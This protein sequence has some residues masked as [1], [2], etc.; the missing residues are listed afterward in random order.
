M[1][2]VE[3]DYL[4][5][6]WLDVGWYEMAGGDFWSWLCDLMPKKEKMKNE[7]GFGIRAETARERAGN[8]LK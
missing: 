5:N 6:G 7:D 2:R 1:V 4:E 3:G 8:M